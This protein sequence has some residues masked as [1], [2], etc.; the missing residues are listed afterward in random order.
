MSVETTLFGKLG[1][2][3]V[4]SYTIRNKSG[5]FV[6]IL[7]F[8]GRIRKIVVPDKNNHFSNVVLGCDSPQEYLKSSHEYY[9]AVIGRCS[10]RIRDGVYVHNNLLYVLSR[11]DGEN[12]LHGGRKG[13]H[14]M[15]WRCCRTEEDLVCLEAVQRHGTE[16]YPGNLRL[17]L[18]YRFSED[19]TLSMTL[20]AQSDR[21]TLFN[22]TNHSFFNLK[23]EGSDATLHFLEIKACEY[24]PA[25]P[26]G[27][28]TGEI[29]DVETSDV[30][31][32]TEPKRILTGL[33]K[34][35]V[36][37]DLFNRSGYDHNYIIKKE[38]FSMRKAAVL[39]SVESGRR[40][41]LYANTPGLQF[42]S[43]NYLDKPRTAICLEPQFF[44]D[45]VHHA[46]DPRWQPIPILEA[47]LLTK[48]E[49]RYQFSVISSEEIDQL[50]NSDD[51]LDDLQI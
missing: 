30:M 35:A 23:E 29:L 5:A 13:F 40:L 47:G 45:A 46:E 15:M 10:N 4:F 9:G 3:D 1:K 24:T 50:T 44:P 8:G 14:N 12:H 38:P 26:D 34:E 43:G 39:T 41:T 6:E 31:N 27:I 19:N 16:G 48:F 37:E 7:D 49:L 17:S 18:T 51:I 22:P 33:K 28:P 20:L 36:C 11:N 2:H 25:G 32:F 42:Y 21:D